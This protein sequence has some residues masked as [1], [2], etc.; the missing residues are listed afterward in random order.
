Q[1]V[2][3]APALPAAAAPDATPFGAAA[4]AATLARTR[5]GADTTVANEMQLSGTVSGNSAANLT[6]GSNLITGGSF[7]NASGLPTVIQNSGANVLIQNATI[8]NLQVH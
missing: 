7:A 3:S 8:I 5:G 6:T 2:L 1:P 4:P